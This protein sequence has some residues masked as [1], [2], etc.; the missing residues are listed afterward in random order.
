MVNNMKMKYEVRTKTDMLV[1][2]FGLRKL[3]EEFAEE[4]GYIVQDI[5]PIGVHN[6]KSWA[7]CDFAGYNEVRIN[8]K[9]YYGK[10][11]M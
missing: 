7:V 9:T 5:S 11:R 10:G 8:G 1:A 3:A 4:N 6:C 2:V